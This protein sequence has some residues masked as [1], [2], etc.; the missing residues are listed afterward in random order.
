M[1]SYTENLQQSATVFQ[2]THPNACIAVKYSPNKTVKNTP[3]R[4]CPTL[5]STYLCCAH[6]Q[7]LL[8]KQNCCF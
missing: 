3:C 8:S 6:S 5:F 7:L 1:T 4:V 2:H